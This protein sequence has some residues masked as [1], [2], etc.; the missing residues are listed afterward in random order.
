[1]TIDDEF[2]K[3]ALII[4]IIL[5]KTCLYTFNKFRSYFLHTF[6]NRLQIF[7]IFTCSLFNINECP[8]KDYK[9]FGEGSN[10]FFHFI[11]YFS[12]LFGM[13]RFNTL[14]HYSLFMVYLVINC[15]QLY[16]HCTCLLFLFY[17]ISLAVYYFFVFIFNIV[18]LFFFLFFKLFTYL[19]YIF[20]F[21]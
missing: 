21:L 4:W 2:A 10:K 13:V 7:F 3:R 5:K 15:S 16:F 19:L 1:M 6:K 11:D 20:V 9:I 12:Y 18:G 17:G 8:L 14:D